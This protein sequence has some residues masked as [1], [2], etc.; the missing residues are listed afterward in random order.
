[1]IIIMDSVL[2]ILEWLD[3]SIGQIFGPKDLDKQLSGVQAA[4]Y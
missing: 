1:M 3:N 4:D 2:V